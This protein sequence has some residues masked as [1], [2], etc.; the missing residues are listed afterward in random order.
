[1]DERDAPPE[2]EHLQDRTFVALDLETTG[3][4]PQ[5]DAIIEVGAV[6]FQG[7]EVIG[8]FQSLVNPYRD[9]PDF[10]QRLTG[11]SQ[12][13]VDGAPSFAGVAG[14][15][16]DF[17]GS[18]PLVGHNLS[19]DLNFLSAHGLQL[20]NEVYDTMDLASVLLPSFTSYSLARLAAEVGADHSRAHR[21][22][23]DARA[24]HGVFLSLVA[25]GREMDPAVSAYIRHLAARSRWPLGRLLAEQPSS[26]NFEVS[27]P[28]LNGLDV[29]DLGRR[30]AVTG[31]TLRHIKDPR[32]VDED[33]LA[34]YISP[35]GLFS[36]SFPEFEYRPQ[37]EEMMRAVARAISAGSHLIV[38]GGTGVG[39]SLAYLLPAIL[40]A[41]A[42][43]TRVVVSTNTINLQEQLLHKDIPAIVAALE[44]GGIIPAGTFKV[45]PLK[46]RANY[47]CL[48]RWNQVARGETLSVDETRLLSKTLM[49]LQD[50]S[51]GDRGE[52]NLS[53]KDSLTWSRVSA[54]DKG[55]CPGMRGEGPCFLRA[56]RGRA[57]GAHLVVV[58][59]A[60]L[61]TD[62]ARGGGLLPEYQHLIIDEAHHLEEQATRQ[63][64]F[65]VSQN[66]L[67]E[68]L[69]A[70]DRLLGDM[71]VLLR[72]SSRSGMQS[73]RV[74]ELAA[75]METQLSRRIR[76]TW[77]RLWSGLETFMNVQ[78]EE[79]GDQAQLRITRSARTQPGWSDIEIAWENVDTTLTDA[80]RQTERL[81]RVLE[82]MPTD[83][84]MGSGSEY[85]DDS[86]LGLSTWQEEVE[87]LQQRL[88]ALL[89]A[90]AEEQRI[91]WISRV[92]EGRG[93]PS[94]GSHIVIHSAPLNVGPELETRLLSKK[95]S[96]VLTSATLSAQ[97]SFDYVRERIG[98]G[99]SEELLVG[100]PFDYGRAALLLIPEDIPLPDEWG[101]QQAMEKLVVSLGKALAGHTLV[102]FTSHA[103]LR[104]AARAVRPL[105]ESEGIP[106]LAQGIDGSPNRIIESFSENPS[107]VILGTSSFWEGVD[108]SGGVLKALVLA[109][110]PFHVPTEPIFAARSGGYQDPFH[111]FALPQAVLR[112]R[113]GIG[114][115]I[116]SSQDRGTVVV[117][118]R[119]ITARKY[120]R[121]FLGSIPPYTVKRSPLSAIPG[122]AAD[123]VG[124]RLGR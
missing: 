20:T 46:G 42:N 37:Q 97:G 75:Q 94:R 93:D 54:G 12:K 59:H 11:I 92:D 26:T 79:G 43:G 96:V 84:P 57:E 18:F 21:A 103:A 70:L 22:L 101:Y 120:G 91:D 3:L 5:R 49:W 32:P 109:R 60:L 82:S 31:G 106:V 117:L 86:M 7:L 80:I 115:L 61:L 41:V 40:Y 66:Q 67:N 74:E 118:D 73:Q 56:A 17:L 28:G 8:T 36:R 29:Q 113:Q 25:R 24:T 23:E 78:S 81:H 35:D 53:G 72:A 9:L 2:L 99:Q 104:G 27:Q 77:D 50:T 123:W 112:F 102:L 34:A 88:K 64:G 90:P 14:E 76:E 45:V 116:R 111:Q 62:L 19:F 44:G 10:I 100:S 71:R 63:L 122:V 98:L 110:L 30:L 85:L 16:R 121:S 1:M 39:K 68:N 58:N 33:E 83:G 48:R 55:Q 38:E 95:R 89:V 119:R 15:L 105:L 52:I 87:E 4:N 65:Q 6:K 124:T 108:L 47:L 69:D 51:T 114:R 13:N 107:G